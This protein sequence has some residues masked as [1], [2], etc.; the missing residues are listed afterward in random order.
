MLVN[1][2]D[3]YMSKVIAFRAVAQET[4]GVSLF[5]QSDAGALA[6]QMDGCKNADPKHILEYVEDPSRRRRPFAA[7]RRSRRSFQTGAEAYS[8]G[9]TPQQQIIHLLAMT[10]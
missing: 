2:T 10:R 5:G 3:P 9:Q 7:P 4:P 1:S 8:R 6:W